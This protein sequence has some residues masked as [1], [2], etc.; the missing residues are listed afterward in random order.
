MGYNG[1]EELKNHPWLKYYN[2]KDLY[3]M[4]EEAPFIPTKQII[5]NE[6]SST[7]NNDSNRPIKNKSLFKKSLQ[8][9]VIIINFLLEIEIN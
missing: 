2:W 3:L 8:I 5:Y 1:I 4:K 6:I 9:S 7:L